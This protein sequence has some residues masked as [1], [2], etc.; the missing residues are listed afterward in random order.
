LCSQGVD[1]HSSS[2]ITQPQDQAWPGS[3]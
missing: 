1:L 2:P 3:G